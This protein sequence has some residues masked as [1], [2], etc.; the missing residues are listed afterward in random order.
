MLLLG[1]LLAAVL[2]VSS[3]LLGGLNLTLALVVAAPVWWLGMLY[4][5]LGGVVV[6]AAAGK[7]IYAAIVFSIAGAAAGNWAR[8][9]LVVFVASLMLSPVSPGLALANAMLAALLSRLRR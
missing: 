3:G 4:G 1:V 7:V 8:A 2:Q 6:G 9:A 5:L